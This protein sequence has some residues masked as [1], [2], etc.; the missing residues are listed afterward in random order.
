[1]WE[2]NLCVEDTSRRVWTS[3]MIVVGDVF[4]QLSVLLR[5]SSIVTISR[6]VHDS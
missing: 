1:M 3:Y 6:L 4:V 2:I 5:L